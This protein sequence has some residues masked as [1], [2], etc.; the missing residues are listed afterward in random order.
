MIDE[1]KLEGIYN[2]IDNLKEEK[3]LL[4]CVKERKDDPSLAIRAILEQMITVETRSRIITILEGELEKNIEAMN[5]E[6]EEKIKVIEEE[7][8][9]QIAEE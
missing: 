8:D 2:L 6:L 3:R 4:E 9:R 5:K 1:N 7:L